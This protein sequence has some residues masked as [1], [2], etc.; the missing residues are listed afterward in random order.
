M[1]S[2]CIWGLVDLVR[3]DLLHLRRAVSITITLLE[4]VNP[5]GM[6]RLVIFIVRLLLVLLRNHEFLRVPMRLINRNI[7]PLPDVFF[8]LFASTVATSHAG[9]RLRTWLTPI[10]FLALISHMVFWFLRLILCCC[11]RLLWMS[12][13]LY[14]GLHIATG[15]CERLLWIISQT[16]PVVFDDLTKT[17]FSTFFIRWLRLRSACLFI[18]TSF[19]TRWM[20]RLGHYLHH[21]WIKSTQA[22]TLR[23][24]VTRIR[25]ILWDFK[26]RF[27]FIELILK[28]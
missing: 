25:D 28:V 22:S 9:D 19:P 3:H 5:W 1:D 11:W 6:Y 12:L 21:T 2:E 14:V 7:L 23:S 8:V 4:L 15:V 26:F 18:P 20:W 17:T 13:Y 16:H 27:K 10:D 24:Y